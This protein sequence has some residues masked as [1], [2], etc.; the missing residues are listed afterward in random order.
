MKGGIGTP[1]STRRP[2]RKVLVVAALAEFISVD[3]IVTAW[4]LGW[5][6]E[7]PQAELADLPSRTPTFTRDDQHAADDVVGPTS[8]YCE[9]SKSLKTASHLLSATTE[10]VAWRSGGGECDEA[11]SRKLTIVGCKTR[12]AAY[13]SSEG[14]ECSV[15][16]SVSDYTDV[17]SVGV[18]GADCAPAGVRNFGSR[19]TWNN[20]DQVATNSLFVD[21]TSPSALIWGRERLIGSCRAAEHLPVIRGVASAI[22]SDG[23]L[24]SAVSRFTEGGATDVEIAIR[25]AGSGGRWV[26]VV[27]SRDCD[28]L[29]PVES[30]GVSAELL[31]CIFVGSQPDPATDLSGDTLWRWVGDHVPVSSDLARSLNS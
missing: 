19:A 27:D 13:P 31:A 17:R 3:I 12:G 2:D 23:S 21:P 18:T 29:Q 10:N 7:G 5:G 14:L 8:S 28:G 11:G 25:R 9:E 26:A 20:Q 6:R 4:A 24:W 1:R 30:G 15:W 16:V 22:C